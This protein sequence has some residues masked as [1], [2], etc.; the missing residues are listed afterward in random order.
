MRYQQRVKPWLTRRQCY[1]D[2]VFLMEH[3]ELS[4]DPP[5]WYDG[6]SAEEKPADGSLG[7]QLI[8]Y[9]I[10]SPDICFAVGYYR[11]KRE[12]K[13]E[14]PRVKTV[15]SRLPP[16]RPTRSGSKQPVRRV[17]KKS[18]PPLQ[19]HRD[20]RSRRVRRRRQSGR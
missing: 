2:M 11:G 13:N 20:W 18:A 15:L 6:P 5:S 7:R 1:E 8:G 16:A 3:A 17:D 19:D 9:L 4:P 12:G 10:V 14:F